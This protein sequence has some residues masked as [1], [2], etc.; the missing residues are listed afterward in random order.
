[1][2]VFLTGANGFLGQ[3][4]YR[5]LTAAG[6]EVIAASQNEC[7]IQTELPV[8][9]CSLN[10]TQKTQVFET[11]Q[12]I[13]PNV[14]IHAAAM[15]KPN[16]CLQQPNNCFTTNVTA[17]DY[18]LQ[19]ATLIAHNVHFIYIST[20]FVFGENGPHAEDDLPHPLNYYGYTKLMAEHLVK[21]SSLPYSIVRP[22]FIYGRQWHGMRPSFLQWVLHA[23][24][25]Q[26]TIQ[27]VSD[28]WRTPTCALDIC[29]GIDAMI[30]LQKTGIYHLAGSEILSPYQMALEIA[31]Y[32]NLDKQFIKKVT[33]EIFPEP[34]QRAKKSGL[35]IDKAVTNLNY[36]PMPFKEGIKWSIEHAHSVAKIF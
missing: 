23:L 1:M 24:Q 36:C 3:H 27:V 32:C 33:A 4:L 12:S 20:D 8:N 34:V 21:Q 10:I 14:I 31:T 2:K 7:R 11:L 15:S 22:V 28:Q 13:Q 19:A 5:Y 35:K 25:H 18:L 29:K 16:E 30:Q 17:T 26:K 9:Y 6:F